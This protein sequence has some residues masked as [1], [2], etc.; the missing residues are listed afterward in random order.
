MRA[1]VIAAGT[2]LAMANKPAPAPST[3]GK[4]LVVLPPSDLP[5]AVLAAGRADAL[6]ERLR[7]ASIITM[8]LRDIAV[9]GNECEKDLGAVLNQ[10][11]LHIDAF[12]SPEIY[13]L[14]DA[15]TK[16]VGKAEL[17]KIAERIVEKKKSWWEESAEKAKALVTT[18]EGRKVAAARAWEELQRLLSGKTQTLV[19]LLEKKEK[20]LGEKQKTLDTQITTFE[21]LK[22]AYRASFGDFAGTVSTM[23][24][25][26]EKAKSEIAAAEAAADPADM[27]KQQDIQE[28]KDKLQALQSRTLALE[29]GLTALPAHQIMVRQ[30]QNA[31]IQTLQ[32]TTTT[33]TARFNNI[34][35]TLLE[36]NGTLA[37]R[38][39]Q[40]A[41][42]AA[43]TLDA[44]L[45]DVQ[46]MLAK[47]V[48]TKAANAAGDN[49]LA[50]ARAIEKIVAD[51]AAIEAL[52]VEGRGNNAVKFAE[53]E[54]MLKDSRQA[55]LTIGQ[56]VRPD[57]ELKR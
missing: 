47:D 46:S 20:E 40:R 29:G 24:A 22:D 52:V 7:A 35:L 19:D 26:L 28:L 38:G 16:E 51:T 37:I 30:L 23:K 25:F 56:K 17:P 8:P 14:F 13:Q 53:A 55:L 41:S 11:L 36:L 31:G 15:L 42:E 12:R 32:E 21:R 43:A 33:A 2:M 48:V 57:Q 34:K 45:A 50:Q 9:L 39:V 6:A 18:A 44:Q 5:P 10:F 4:E 49:R 27:A 1:T 54:T 3:E